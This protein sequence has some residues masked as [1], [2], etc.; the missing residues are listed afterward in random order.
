MPPWKINH[1][2]EEATQEVVSYFQ[3]EDV[4]HEIKRI[5]RIGRHPNVYGQ[6][7]RQRYQKLKGD[8]N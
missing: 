7:L 4:Q 8:K 6:A 1:L 5:L 3:D 2:D